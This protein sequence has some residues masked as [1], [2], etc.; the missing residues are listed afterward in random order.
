[1]KPGEPIR[2]VEGENDGDYDPARQR[3]ERI[4]IGIVAAIVLGL[5]LL[6]A[7]LATIGSSIGYSGNIA[8]FAL[9]NINVILIVLLIFLVTR[10]VF[11][12]IL[13]RKRK[14]LGSRIRSRLV[15]LFTA[16]S[17]I[18]TILL[19]IAAATITTTNIRSWIG[20]R[21]GVA[22]TDALEIARMDLNADAGA[23]KEFVTRIAPGLSAGEDGAASLSA[24]RAG[25]DNAISLHLL[26]GGEVL[27]TDGE[28]DPAV[29]SEIVSRLRSGLKSG[30][31]GN[32]GTLIGDSYAAAAIALP[33]GK[34][35]VAV[36]LLPA[37]QA[38]RIRTIAEAYDEY[39]QVRLLDDP[40]RA[41]YIG[42]LI[43]ITLLI[44]FAAS[45]MGIYLA[46]QITVPVKSMAEGMQRVAGGDLDVHLDY[47]SDDE[48]GYLVES[49][50]RMIGDL[51]GMKLNLETANESLSTT[52]DELKRRTQFIETILG[53]ISTAVV[54][55][56]RHGRIAMIN[57]VAEQML[58]VTGGL[59]I[60]KPYREALLEEHYEAV[61]ILSR[62]LGSSGNRQ[63]ERQV[64]L[65]VEGKKIL[66]R[67]RITALK[68][69]EGGHLGLVVA[70]DDMSQTMR[71]QKVLA[72]REIARRI[73]HEIRNP[74]TPIQ[75]SAERLQRKFGAAHVDD[76]AFDDCTQTIL[77]EIGTLKI[78]MDEFTRFSRMP[79]PTLVAGDL[80]EELRSTV[81]IFRT[82]YPGIRCDF[83]SDNV[84]GVHF[85]AF[86]M[87]RALTNLLENAASALSGKGQ[88]RVKCVR[89]QEMDWVRLSVADDGPGIREED[90]EHLFEP[91]FSRKEGGTGLG[92]AIV[93]AIAN[94][95]GGVVEVRDNIPSGA[96]FV[97]EFPGH[98]KG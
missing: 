25:S 55:L 71:L 21:V 12:L 37:E 8:I 54:V 81:D 57:R 48:F 97:M 72:W 7:N 51:K 83:E 47:R 94:D 74:L 4:A 61:R 22:L 41:S 89:D 33:G 68:D 96:L 65:P 76:P 39:H 31:G 67:V 9:I 82:K 40:I 69:D 2:T 30:Q 49:F 24:L 78:L 35:L 66:L 75:L 16:F 5:T 45:W 95:H 77:S 6:E 19:F 59:A 80:G 28:T 98:P 34:T 52:Y 36:R 64:E 23:M 58:G 42:L 15:V 73:A 43:L 14:I 13:D 79:T 93:S 32:A 92:L 62:E 70:F 53:N 3:R 20:G 27:S 18:P 29:M 44:V 88:V 60:G 17:L 84:S 90:R 85:D 50:N 87:R 56:D 10:N 11:K 86:Q 1:M 63:V 91:Y 38:R 26:K 46:K